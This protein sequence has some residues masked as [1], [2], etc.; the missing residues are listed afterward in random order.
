VLVGG[1]DLGVVV[2]VLVGVL[3]IAA[4]NRILEVAGV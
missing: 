2:A 4:A 3:V 1:F